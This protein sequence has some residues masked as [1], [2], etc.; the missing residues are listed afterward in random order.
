M[1]GKLGRARVHVHYVKIFLHHMEKLRKKGKV[2]PS[3][4]GGVGDFHLNF[5]NELENFQLFWAMPPHEEINTCHPWSS[6]SAC[7]SSPSAPST[8][9]IGWQLVDC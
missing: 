7:G 5:E 8:G 2:T 3:A 1:G 6:A 4:D 9:S